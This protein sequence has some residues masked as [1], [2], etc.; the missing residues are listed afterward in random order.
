[1]TLFRWHV[2]VFENFMLLLKKYVLGEI[3]MAEWVSIF[4]NLLL[5][6]VTFSTVL[7]A[8]RTLMME[9]SSQVIVSRIRKNIN[10]RKYYKYSWKVNVENVGKGYIVKA[11]ILLTVRPKGGFR[12]YYYLS[13]PAVGINP[14]ESRTLNLSLKETHLEN[15]DLIN[16][17]EKVEVI[18]QDAVNNIYCVEPGL[19]N[20]SDFHR[21][22]ESFDKLPKKLNKFWIN[23]WIY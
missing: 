8:S 9:Y 1:I 7:Y 21:H 12:K 5:V 3:L 2:V 20:V 17:N 6:L 13:K 16:N 15:T 4:I 22:L 10:T 14:K 11:F 23:Y 19:S 18:Y